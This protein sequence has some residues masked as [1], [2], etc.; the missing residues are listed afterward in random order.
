MRA[1]NLI[2]LQQICLI[3]LSFFF[4]GGGTTFKIVFPFKVRNR[5]SP[6]S[7]LSLFQ[8]KCEVFVMVS[9]STFNVYE[10]DR[11]NRLSN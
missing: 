7:L 4:F 10:T 8:G 6:G 2:I 1:M 9:S 3:Y 5:A 11:H